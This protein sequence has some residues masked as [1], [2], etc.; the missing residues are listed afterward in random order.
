MYQIYEILHKEYPQMT[1]LSKYK[2]PEEKI[3]KE[4]IEIN[5]QFIQILKAS[6]VQLSNKKLYNEFLKELAIL[7]IDFNNSG[8]S[9]RDFLYSNNTF[10]NFVSQHQQ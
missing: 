4:V 6:N 7:L 3:S 1:Y 9:L 5:R 2:K 8:K 10:K